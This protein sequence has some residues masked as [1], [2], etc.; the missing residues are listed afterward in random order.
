MHHTSM[1][2]TRRMTIPRAALALWIAVSA[3]RAAPVEWVRAHDLYQRTEYRQSL[4]QLLALN[5]K[6]AAT[7][8]LMGQNYF[9]LGEYKKATESLEKAAAL[10]PGEGQAWL[11]LGRAYGRRAETSN[12]FSAPGYATKA[13]QMFERAVA[14]DPSN[15]EAFGD[16][17]DFYLDAPG[18]LGGGQSKAEALAA[19]VGQV[20]PAEGLYLQAQIDDRR[21][22]FDS[23][24]EKLRRAIEIAPAQ[25]GRFLELAKFLARRGRIEESEAMFEEAARLAPNNPHQMFDRASLYIKQRRNLAEARVLL[26]RYLRLPLTPGDPPRDR[27]EVL[28]KKIEP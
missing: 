19:R 18:F 1:P 28:L 3:G 9:M 10:A 4:V 13:R 24:E 12:P 16:L 26:E 22:Q 8:Q 15:K 25:A 2:H 11:W 23:A 7:L 17:F 27:A 20:D 21:N 6:D 14:L 5:P